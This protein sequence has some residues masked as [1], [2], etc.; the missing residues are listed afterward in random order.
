[1][2]FEIVSDQE[3]VFSKLIEVKNYFEFVFQIGRKNRLTLFH[4]NFPE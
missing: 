1:V 3:I 2:Q 4:P